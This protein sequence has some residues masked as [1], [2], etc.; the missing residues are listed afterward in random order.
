MVVDILD[1]VIKTISKAKKDSNLQATTY[2][3]VF[4][5]SCSEDYT[6]KY[7]KPIV[8]LEVFKSQLVQK[9]RFSTLLS[10]R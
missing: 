2:Q 6:P 8:P 5:K 1:T 4:Q 10:L 9:G 7:L 3:D